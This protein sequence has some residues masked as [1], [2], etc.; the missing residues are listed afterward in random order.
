MNKTVAALA[1]FMV[2]FG[3][4]YAEDIVEDVTTGKSRELKLGAEFVF[5]DQDD[6]WDS[7][8]GAEAK[9][10]FWQDEK[11]GFAASIGLQ[12]WDVNDDIISYGKY[13][14][15]GVAYG[16]AAGLE[17]DANMIPLGFSGV[18]RN[19]IGDN[20]T[21]VFEGGIRYVVV[22]SSVSFGYAEALVDDRGNY[23]AWSEVLDVDIDD[24]IVGFVG[25][26][27]N[28]ELKS[29]LRL[30]AGAGFQFDLSKG[31]VSVAGVD[32][33]YENELKAT[34][35]RVGAAWDI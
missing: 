19:S 30:F 21:L 16:F 35:V 23:I 7:G 13:L 18:Y 11:F 27:I 8:F 20:T 24:G 14:G 4:C 15:G 34:F 17:G 29:G 1:A 12:K 2:T 26:D 28:H 6:D 3:H 10:I 5:P 32:T 9:I 25:A 31:D 33:G 22:D